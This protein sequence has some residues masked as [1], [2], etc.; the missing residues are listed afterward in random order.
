MDSKEQLL[1]KVLKMLAQQGLSMD[2]KTIEKIINQT[3]E[4]K[5]KEDLKSKLKSTIKGEKL[6]ED[7]DDDDIPDKLEIKSEKILPNT[8]RERESE[9]NHLS[10]TLNVSNIQGYNAIPSATMESGETDFDQINL[11]AIS[12]ANHRKSINKLDIVS[13]NG[14]IKNKR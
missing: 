10:S 3:F 7:D 8:R 11:V 6:D 14:R 9:L 5:S 1:K 12:R 4:S 2:E 13:S